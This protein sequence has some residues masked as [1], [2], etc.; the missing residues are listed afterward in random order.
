MNKKEIAEIKR[1]FSVER[2]PLTWIRGCYVDGE[3]NRKAEMGRPFLSLPEAEMFKYFD[4]F[5][6]T[7][8]GKLGRN[9]LNLKPKNTAPLLAMRNGE[10]REEDIVEAFYKG[11]D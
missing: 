11:G 9:I 1:L 6:K 10:L 3:K 5:K 8:S 4:I 2:T 7:L